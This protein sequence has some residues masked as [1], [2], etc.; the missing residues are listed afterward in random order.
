MNQLLLKVADLLDVLGT[1][2]TVKRAETAP[3]PLVTKVEAR[4][5]SQLPPETRSKL[6]NDEGLRAM[7]ASLVAAPEAPQ[8]LGAPSEKSARAPSPAQD[9][10]EERMRQANDHFARIVMSRHNS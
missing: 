4:L 2:T 8:P 3:D 7:A 1:E 9:S 6:A 5:G 10:P